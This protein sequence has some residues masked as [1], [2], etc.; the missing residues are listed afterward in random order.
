MN[1]KHAGESFAKLL[2]SR[3]V[4]R[5][6]TAEGGRGRPARNSS[7]PVIRSAVVLL[8][9]LAGAGLLAMTGCATT[10]AHSNA[11]DK[12]VFDESLVAP[13]APVQPVVAQAAPPPPAA[14][15]SK[16]APEP[17]TDPAANTP[18]VST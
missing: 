17:K 4:L 14:A 12:N 18:A 8:L 6:S 2:Q 10:A 13:P 9:A 3:P 7:T 1:T 11:S 15:P 16:A 5:S